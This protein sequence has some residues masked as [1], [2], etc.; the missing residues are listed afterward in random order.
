MQKQ[1]QK[2]FKHY[3]S[4]I[5]SVDGEL[6]SA[7]QVE[8]GHLL[9][10]HAQVS[11]PQHHQVLAVEIGLHCKQNIIF[12]KEVKHN[13]SSP[14]HALHAINNSYEIYLHSLMM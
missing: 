9:V 7:R 1:Q 3:I 12:L 14:H 10:V 11:L 4:V 6:A 2:A 13:K 8:H 5:R